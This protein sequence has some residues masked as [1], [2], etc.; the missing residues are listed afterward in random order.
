MYLVCLWVIVAAVL[1]ITATNWKTYLFARLF[2]G[3][4]VGLVQS[5]ITVYISEVS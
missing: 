4:A 1:E 2:S 5:G 3:L